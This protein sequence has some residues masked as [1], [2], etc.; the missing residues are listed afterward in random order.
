MMGKVSIQDIAKFISA[1]HGLSRQEAETFVSTLFDVISDG[2]NAE[3]AVKV[4]GLG[5]FKVIDV[6]ERESVNVNTGERVVIEGHGKITFTPDPVMR[7]LVNKP[8]AQFETVVLNEG[9]DLDEMSKV[10]TPDGVPEPQEQDG[11][12][13]RDDVETPDL[14]VSEEETV[15]VAE[16]GERCS[17]GNE[18]GVETEESIFADAAEQ[19]TSLDAAVRQEPDETELDGDDEPE[20]E[21]VKDETAGETQGVDGREVADDGGEDTAQAVAEDVRVAEDADEY[22]EN[23]DIEPEN[24][25]V[26]DDA[27]LDEPLE[28]VTDGSRKRWLLPVSVVAAAVLSF[29]V[30]YFWGRSSV[31]PVVKYKTVRI[32][33]KPVAKVEPKDTV[34]RQDSALGAVK[35]DT[36]V[37]NKPQAVKDVAVALP[38]TSSRVLRNAQAVVNTGAYRIVGTAKTVTVKDGETLAGIARLYF[39]NGMEC[40]IQVHNGI[41]DVKPGMKLKIPKLELKRKK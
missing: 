7:D 30:G 2:L 37:V 21:S 11:E 40:Y 41:E 16:D 9:V 27:T 3:K 33:E 20:T 10:Q 18:D 34:A 38:E 6:R 32:V 17:E 22:I 29:G 35:P 15:P 19:P 31:D 24:N 23:E 4:K 36:T 5:T 8:F 39:G 25:D 1:K 12:E 14:L 26:P 13:E 28:D